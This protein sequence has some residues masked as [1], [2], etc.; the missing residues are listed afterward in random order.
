MGF[1]GSVL[2]PPSQATPN[3][4]S[5][6]AAAVEDLSSMS[7]PKVTVVAGMRRFVET[8]AG[9][10]RQKLTRVVM[11]SALVKSMKKAPTMGTTRKARGAG[12]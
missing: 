4:R 9:R 10:Y 3:E 2:N 7:S 1:R 5:S 8:L 11:I 12:P 6:S